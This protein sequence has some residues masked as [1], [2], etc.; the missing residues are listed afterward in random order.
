MG[1]LFA[2]MSVSVWYPER[3]KGLADTDLE[4]T[5]VRELPRGFGKGNSGP[6]EEHVTT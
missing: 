4:L 5:D 3:P 6:G 2:C 1:V